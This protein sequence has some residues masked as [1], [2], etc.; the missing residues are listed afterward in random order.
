M[1][2]IDDLSDSLVDPSHMLSG[3]SSLKLESNSK[4]VSL[5]KITP[6]NKMNTL[7]NTKDEK[8]FANL[9]LDESCKVFS[10]NKKRKTQLDISNLEMIKIMSQD[11][12]IKKG[13]RKMMRERTFT[14]KVLFGVPKSETAKS[15]LT[16]QKEIREVKIGSKI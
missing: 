4:Q 11:N 14:P 6:I 15:I 16:F 13:D 12:F 2:V 10:S 3:F 9:D 5:K 7:D 8:T 1:Q